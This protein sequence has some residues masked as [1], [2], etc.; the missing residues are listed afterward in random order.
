MAFVTVR[1]ASPAIRDFTIPRITYLEDA[2]IVMTKLRGGSQG[3]SSLQYG[4]GGRPFSKKFRIFETPNQ[5]EVAKNPATTN[6]NA[7]DKA[8]ALAG[9]GTTQGAGTAITKY[10]NEC[11][12]IGAGATEA[13][14]L[15]AAVV[16]KVRVFVNNDAAGDQAKIFPASGEK[17]ITKLGVDLGTN[18]VFSLLAAQRAHF[19][20]LATGI[21]QECLLGQ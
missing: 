7:Q 16:G 17:I 1:R 6:V 2:Q 14:T 9:A 20:C 10:F 4:T 13:F 19:V 21:W 12:T 5:L 3:G 18:A 15:D 11:L 8:L